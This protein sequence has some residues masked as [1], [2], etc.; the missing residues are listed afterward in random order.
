MTAVR[1]LVEELTAEISEAYARIVA[2]AWGLALRT[3]QRGSSAV[4]ARVVQTVGGMMRAAHIVMT[5]ADYTEEDMS[6][7]EARNARL[8]ADR[9]R[10][11]A[12]FRADEAERANY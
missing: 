12:A 5:L 9:K 4:K 10:Y 2:E 8:K 6:T 11:E 3:E 7:E 1:E